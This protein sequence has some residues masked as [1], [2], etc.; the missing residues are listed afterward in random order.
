MIVKGRIRLWQISAL[1][2]VLLVLSSFGLGV[3]WGPSLFVPHLDRV[4]LGPSLSNWLGSDSLGRDVALRCWEAS[5]RSILLGLGAAAVAFAFGTLVG[6]FAA[7]LG[8]WWNWSLTRAME[9]FSAIPQLIWASVFLFVLKVRFPEV[10]TS[11]FVLSVVLGSTGWVFFARSARNLVLREKAKGYCE[12]SVAIGATQWR[13]MFVHLLPNVLPT[14]LVQL[15]L[16]VPGFLL[17]ESFLSFLGVG[18][19]SPQV[20]WG[21]ILQDG[22]RY[23]Q[24]A[25][26]LLLAPTLFLFATTF[27]VHGLLHGLKTRWLRGGTVSEA[28]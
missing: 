5:H 19:Q 22:W 15:G 25:P 13:V 7:F 8:G 12:A 24:V 14:L 9:V 6:G 27:L 3:L 17:F 10:A 23:L 26:H 16:A 21:L 11:S 4:L 28:L 1:L 20:S 2:L 18:L